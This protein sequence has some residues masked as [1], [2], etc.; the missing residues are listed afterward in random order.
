MSKNLRVSSAMLAGAVVI[1][2]CALLSVPGQTQS[3]GS[4]IALQAA[5]PGTMQTGN[6]NVSGRGRMANF[7]MTNGAAAGR[8][9]T[10]DASGN[11]SWATLPA[12]GIA[13]PFIGNY[14]GA[15]IMFDLNMSG[16]AD[17]GNFTINNAASAAEAVQGTT[18]GTGDA[19]YGLTTGTGRGGIFQINNSSNSNS[20]VYGT[21]NGTGAGVF[22]NNSHASSGYGVLGRSVNNIGVWGDV[23]GT[24]SDTNYG[25]YGRTTGTNGRAVFGL[26]AAT[27]GS[28]Y[29]G[30]FQNSSDAGFGVYGQCISTTGTTYGVFGRIA[31]TAGRG[32][33]GWATASTGTTYGGYF[34]SDSSS[35]RGVYGVGDVYGVQGHSENGRGIYGTT[36]YGFGNAIEGVAQAS[37]G[38]TQNYG[39]AGKSNGV[40]GTGVLGQALA[41]SSSSYG[42]LGDVTNANAFAVYALGK[43]GASGTKSFRIDHPDDPANKYLLHYSAESPDVL[44]MYSG[45]IRLNEAGDAIV[46][47]PEYFSKINKDARIF[48]TAAGAPMPNL[49]ASE[50]VT[51]NQFEI[52]GGRPNGKVFWEVKAIR[53]DE[54]MKRY[55]APVEVE[56]QGIEKGRYQHPELYGYGP[57]M[58]FV[59][60][61]QATVKRSPK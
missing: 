37:G 55:G 40:S 6:F 10:S 41:N 59:Q 57:E 11:A 4:F 19:V 58:K 45:S 31:S 28:T 32:V 42:V 20:G 18:N 30:L 35:G 9:L 13:F 25:V 1:A 26:A 51:G 7:T 48:L 22:G 56:K 3:G 2:G 29:S 53:N 60:A 50:E 61:G 12:D 15:S 54:W 46:E 38:V 23:T 52:R 14:A 33:T 16:T 17:C 34:Q 8:W 36:N 21:T 43:F 44:N 49:Y 24:G 47:L 27:T 5:S 39:V